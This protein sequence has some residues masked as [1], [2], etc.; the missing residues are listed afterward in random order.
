MYQGTISQRNLC[1]IVSRRGTIKLELK[2]SKT[3]KCDRQRALIKEHKMK[4][5]EN[6]EMSTVYILTQAQGY[7]R[8]TG[9]VRKRW[10][11]IS[12]ISHEEQS[13]SPCIQPT[14]LYSI[15]LHGEIFI[16]QSKTR[17]RR[18]TKYIPPAIL[19]WD[20]EQD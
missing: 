7:V 19:N 2:T 11:T 17:T 10:N 13:F 5:L 20:Q 8:K 15:L 18:R 16:L 14:T 4:R 1:P 9:L 12:Q 6:N 3:M